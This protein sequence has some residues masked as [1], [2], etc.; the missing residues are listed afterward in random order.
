MV[1]DFTAELTGTFQLDPTRDIRNVH[2]APGW[3]ELVTPEP[4]KAGEYLGELF[5]W[6]FRTTQVAGADYRIILVGG[7]EV[8]GIRQP[9]PGEPSD[10]RWDT[11][12]TVPTPTSS[13]SAPPPPAP[14]SWSPHATRRRGPHDRR[15]PSPRRPHRRLRVPPSLQVKAR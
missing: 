1:N 14:R 8:G 15:R 13:P 10:P 3:F 6:E 11:Y 2:G 4:D 5:G 12:V 9:Q 7:H